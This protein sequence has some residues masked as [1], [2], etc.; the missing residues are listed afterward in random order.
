MDPIVLPKVQLGPILPEIVMTVLVCA[1]ILVDLFLSPR[2]KGFSGFLALAGLV[3]A[4]VF[5]AGRIGTDVKLF[6][7]MYR[8]DDFSTFFK[9]IFLGVAFLTILISF[10][11]LKIEDINRGEYYAL[12][13]FS[14]IGMMV[15]ASGNDL[16]TIYIGLELLSIPVY[17]LVGFLKRDLMSQEGGIK[18]F[19]LGIF[20]SAIILYGIAL[21]Y[22]Y[23]GTLYL[24]GIREAL[25]PGA[26]QAPGGSPLLTL[27]IILLTAGFAFKV[28]LVPFHMWAPDAYQGAPTSITAFM[29]VGTKAGAFAA[30]VRVFLVAFGDSMDQW[31][32]LLWLLAVVS[33]TWGNIAAMVQT[34]LKR[35]L[36]YSS[37]AHAGYILIGLVVATR[38]GIA[39]IL[40]YLAAYL[41]TNLGAF[42]VI[43]LLCRPSLR[44][45]RLEDFRGLARQHPWP[46]L[47]L[48]FFFLSLT[49]LPPT[50]GFVGK[51]YIFSAAVDAGFIWLAVIGLLNSAI[52]LYYYFR[53]VM[54]MY[55]HEPAGKIHTSNSVPLTVGLAVMV[56][57][58]LVIGVYPHPFL[59]AAKVSVAGLFNGIPAVALIP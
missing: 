51:F 38:T 22:G 14:T 18:Y 20:S 52:S 9:F 24:D 6:G 56:A 31:R 27:A 26:G 49:G 21:I 43:I 45:D 39:S 34:N 5:L 42:A 16:L 54:M 50:A 44:G 28:A 37:V 12:I 19:L 32:I 29:S 46:A 3:V 25:A 7:G 23:T 8:V 53:V 33:M 35:M 4:G 17:L 36:A 58:V 13:L 10:R 1:I 47:A 41:F 55:M 2:K 30:V 11:Y 40:L 48:L 15:L 59:E 57:G